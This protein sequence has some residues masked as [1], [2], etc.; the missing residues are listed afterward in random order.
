M[1]TAFYHGESSK[2][3]ARRIASFPAGRERK[4]QIGANVYIYVRQGAANRKEEAPSFF[5]N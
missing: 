2:R 4:R 3:E 5:L 1:E